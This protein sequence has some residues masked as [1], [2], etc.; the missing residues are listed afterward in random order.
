MEGGGATELHAVA[1]ELGQQGGCGGGVDQ[2]GEEWRQPKGKRGRRLEG[3]EVKAV[4][5]AR[6]AVVGR[7]G[8]GESGRRGVRSI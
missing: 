3:V 5:G 7:S 8:E 2:R 1:S 4:S 6:E